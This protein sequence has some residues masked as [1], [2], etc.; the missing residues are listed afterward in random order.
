MLSVELLEYFVMNF[1][2]LVMIMVNSK[3]VFVRQI[4]QCKL[5]S[6]SALHLVHRFEV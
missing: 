4:S 2:Q 5:S 3:C 1:V 6:V